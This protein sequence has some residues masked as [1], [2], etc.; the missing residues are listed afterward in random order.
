MTE[1]YAQPYSIE[2]TGFFFNSFENFEAG[3]EK[4][5]KRGCEEVEIQI[6]DGDDHLVR[7]ASTATI[8]QGDIAFWYDA[9]EDLDQTEATQMIVLLDLGY[10]LSDALERYE[11]V[12]LFDGS[13]ADYA[14]DLINETC[15]VPDH[16]RNYIDYDAIAR[17]MELG[18]EITAI[19]RE[20]IVTNANEF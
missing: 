7:L 5:N 1:F 4:L 10:S 15:E 16:L 12:C 17:D 13:A 2:H 11:E 18:G 3:M 19:S 20:L 8:H 9:L 6:I 14:Y